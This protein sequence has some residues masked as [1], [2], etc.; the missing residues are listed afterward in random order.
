MMPEVSS[1]IDLH[2]IPVLWGAF[3]PTLFYRNRERLLQLRR[4]Y[5]LTQNQGEWLDLLEDKNMTM[6]DRFF[7]QFPQ[8]NEVA[9]SLKAEL[10]ISSRYDLP[11]ELNPA[12]FVATLKERLQNSKG[13]VI[14]MGRSHSILYPIH[15]ALREVMERPSETR[16]A[17]FVFDK[18]IDTKRIGTDGIQLHYQVEK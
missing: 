17:E 4:D 7:N 2:H 6:V 10:G 8:W 15:I 16:V 14:V 12:E 18:L 11:T 9:D 5:R 1:S 3:E 13:N